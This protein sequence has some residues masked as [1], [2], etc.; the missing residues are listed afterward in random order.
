MTGYYRKFVKGYDQIAAPLTTLL[1]KDSFVWTSKA[2]HAFQLLMDAM[3]NP[4]VLALP[5]FSKPF[6]IECDASRSSVGAVLM[7]NQRP[8]AFHNQALKGK[9]LAFSTYEKEL[10]ALVVAMKKWRPYLLGRPFVI[11]T[12]HPQ[13]FARI[14]NWNSCSSKMDHQAS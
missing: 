4:L 1:R 9:N 2:S 10:L 7:Q 12:N 14:K 3:S 6:V 5:N 8:I 11:N 13:I